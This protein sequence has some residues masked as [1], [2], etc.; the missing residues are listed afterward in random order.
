MKQYLLTGFV[1]LGVS[2]LCPAQ[3]GGYRPSI[4][5]EFRKE[6]SSKQPGFEILNRSIQNHAVASSLASNAG[7]INRTVESL[8]ESLFYSIMD[9][10]ASSTIS[11]TLT[12]KATYEREV[13]ATGIGT[14]VVFDRFRIGPEIL[15]DIGNLQGLPLTFR[16]QN[17]LFLTNV[18]YRSD[19]QRKANSQTRSGWREWANNWFGGLPLL[20]RIL[21]PSFNPEELYDPISY[22]GTPFLFPKNSEQALQMP[23]GTVRSYGLSGSAGPSV[24][25]AGA[26]FKN[27]QEA[28]SLGDLDLGIPVGGFIEGEHQISVLHTRDN[29]VWLAV[30]EIRQLGGILNFSLGKRYQIFQHLVKWWTGS[31]AVIAPIDFEIERSKILQRDELYTFDLSKV[32]A[33]QALDKALNGDLT[34]AKSFSMREAQAEESGVRFQFRR[35][36]DRGEDSSRQARSLFVL[37]SQKRDRINDGE[38]TILDKEGEFVTLEAEHAVQ[39]RDWNVLTGA[40]TVDVTFRYGLPVLKKVQG[41]ETFY[42]TVEQKE[43]NY[44]IAN[45]RIIDRFHDTQDYSRSVEMLR[46]FSHLP[47]NQVPELPIYA[48]DLEARFRREQAF[49]NPMD[50]AFEK[51]VPPTHL[52]RFEAFSHVYINQETLKN[53]GR[54]EPS[55]FWQA[56]AKSFG[57]DQEYWAKATDARSASYYFNWMGSFALM[58]LKLLNVKT[59]YSDFVYEGQAI[60][61]ALQ[62][63]ATETE[64][65]KIIRAYRQLMNTNHPAEL[66]N[67]L[68]EMSPVEI[69]SVVGF[70]TSPDNNKTDTEDMKA[71]KKSFGK[72][73]NRKVQT[74]V[75]LPTLKRNQSVEEKLAA[76]TPG[77]YADETNSPQLRQITLAVRQTPPDPKSRLVAQV[78]VTG[79]DEH[80]EYLQGYIRVEENGPLSLGRFVLGEEVKNLKY[81]KDI[82]GDGESRS[83]YEIELN[84]NGGLSKADFFDAALAD[85]GAFD[86][87][88][89]VSNQEDNWGQEQK[90]SFDIQNGLLKDF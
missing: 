4:S 2:S 21:P 89:S 82:S 12:A 54:L 17:K 31:I 53:I 84:G 56:Y 22:L 46:R 85:K 75:A 43:P 78:E 1:L 76:F 50:T 16:N 19:A 71:V 26:H 86:L 24:D 65:L 51:D 87:Y 52:G 29:E 40:E 14:Y 83:L 81:L 41:G 25:I 72:L 67:T 37:Q 7:E 11:D 55:A 61:G 47:L 90:L 10:S 3:I 74:H 79:N 88:F 80:K 45:L 70:T 57:L 15:K 13:Q 20:T 49:Q 6:E 28:L 77:G 38:S 69:P 33:R 34:L 73:N 18:S 62:T 36:S 8:M 30:S 68:S 27:A 66:L 32:D 58:P 44:L 42:K 35:L 64:P 48:K 59:S 5:K 9:Q 23:L 63:I 39:D 60:A